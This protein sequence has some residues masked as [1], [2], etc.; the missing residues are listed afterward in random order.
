MPLTVS[1]NGTSSEVRV[2]RIADRKCSTCKDTIEIGESYIRSTMF[3]M[4]SWW[5]SIPFV[6]NNWGFCCVPLMLFEKIVTR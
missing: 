6:H 3:P 4:D 5:D 1:Y 2:N